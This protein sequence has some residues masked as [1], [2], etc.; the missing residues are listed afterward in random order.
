[1][2]LMKDCVEICL[3]YKW[4]TKLFE[5]VLTELKHYITASTCSYRS[6]TSEDSLSQTL[7]CSAFFT[8]YMTFELVMYVAKKMGDEASVSTLAETSSQFSSIANINGSTVLLSD[9]YLTPFSS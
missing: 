2:V 6:F 4:C 9:L 5:V 8:A 7:S 3:L 1:M